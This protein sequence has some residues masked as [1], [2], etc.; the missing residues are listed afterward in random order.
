MT[1]RYT[2]RQSIQVAGATLLTISAA[3][4]V[5]TAKSTGESGDPPDLEVINNSDQ[6]GTVTV[7]VINKE[8]DSP[9]ISK[10]IVLTGYSHSSQQGKE[11][12]ER[13]TNSLLELRGISELPAGDYSLVVRFKDNKSVEDFGITEDGLPADLYFASEIDLD[14]SISIDKYYLCDA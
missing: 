14:L 11:M 2:R 13:L 8:S 6:R 7:K 10:S 3:G 12:A 9:V 5:S 1:K 4:E